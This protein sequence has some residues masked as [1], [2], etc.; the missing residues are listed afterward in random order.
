MA[1]DRTVSVRTAGGM[2]S[3]V[4]VLSECWSRPS[5][6]ALELLWRWLFGV[7][8]L[9]LLA[10]DGLQIYAAVSSQLAVAGI[11]QFSI[12]DPMRAA[13]IAS[14]VYAIIT[15]PIVRTA[16][17]LVPVAV[18]A[19]AIVSGIGRNTVLRR[20][21]LSLPRR[22]FTLILLQLLRI[23]FLGG[24]FAFWFAAIQWSADYA[25]A[26]DE[27]N[28][29]AYCA[30]VICLSLGIFTLWALVS[31][32]FSIAP[33]LVLLEN[34]GVASSLVRS[35]RLGPLTG[36]LVEVNLVMSI[37]KLALIVLAMVFSTIPLP[38][39]SDM[40]GP[41]LYAWWAVVSVLY[42]IASDFFQVA[43]LVAFIQFWRAFQLVEADASP[44][45][46]PSK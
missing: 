41:P 26:G 22:P 33:L 39:A 19:W 16:L 4:H 6:L 9:A 17:W 20:Y 24:S 32:V 28:L 5:L 44:K 40:E 31:W 45:F 42:L 29:V 35:L 1:V 12:V 27:P 15:P 36:Q 11:D 25:L 10:Y 21:D 8:L 14:G 2:Q 30:L 13:E 46:A 38:F 3:F 37:I 34:R 7:P 43:R 23:A 18:F